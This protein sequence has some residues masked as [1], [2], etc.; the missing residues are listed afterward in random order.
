M[1]ILLS[2]DI[3]II[4]HHQT[5]PTCLPRSR[6]QL[7]VPEAALS[8]LPGGEVAALDLG[9]GGAPA[10]LLVQGG[11]H[12]P[13]LI[14]QA[15]HAELLLSPWWSDSQWEAPLPGCC[16]ISPPA[17]PRPG[18][19]TSH[20]RSVSSLCSSPPAPPRRNV[21]V[22]TKIRPM[23]DWTTVCCTA[24]LAPSLSHFTVR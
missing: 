22:I 7:R 20:R 6:L 12:V 23:C 21:Q 24:L 11:H 3:N 18:P 5:S 10:L 2:L 16:F 17:P 4:K 9:H 19:H 1:C 8:P 15:D 13:G 14:L